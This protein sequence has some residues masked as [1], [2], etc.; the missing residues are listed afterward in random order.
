M[1]ESNRILNWQQRSETIFF[2]QSAFVG[3]DYLAAKAK[4]RF[5]TVNP[6]TETELAIFTDSDATAVN[7]AVAAAR[8]AFTHWRV[9][10]LDK[11]KAVQIITD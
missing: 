2:N 1:I 7:S 5:T 6:S 9:L 8:K 3:G 10:S 11:R 4:D